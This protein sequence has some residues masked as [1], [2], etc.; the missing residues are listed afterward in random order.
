MGR[1]EKLEG[2]FTKYQ[3]AQPLNR[4]IYS[5]I[6]AFEATSVNMGVSVK[7]AI[8]GTEHY[9]LDQ[10]WFDVSA[11]SLLIVNHN[12][13]MDITVTQNNPK[14]SVKGICCYIEP[15]I[16]QQ[17][18]QQSQL[19]SDKQLEVGSANSPFTKERMTHQVIPIGLTK[20]WPLFN[21]ILQG[22]WL[23]P[24]E[25]DD[26][27]IKLAE[28]LHE[29]EQQSHQQIQSIPASRKTTREELYRRLTNARSY[30]HDRLAEK[31]QIKDAAQAANLSSYHFHRAFSACFGQTPNQYLT[32]IRL[33]HAK[34]LLEQQS[35]PINEVAQQSG[36]PDAKYF[37]KVFKR[38]MKMSP[39]DYT[40]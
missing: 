15:E 21:L 38:Y 32:H 7:Y 1:F 39:S 24:E 6:N 28:T 27:M 14:S 12:T 2:N 33:E 8:Q 37:S 34:R 3:G 20:M 22:Q 10:N 16:V 13:S 4:I 9:R 30:L 11:R 40:R 23:P 29:F 26:L 36:F 35:L 25:V 17:I 18:H 19:S 31:I 5:D